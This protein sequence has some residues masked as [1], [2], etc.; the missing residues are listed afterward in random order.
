M[1][2]LRNLR[3]RNRWLRV[4]RWLGRIDSPMRGVSGDQ[5]IVESILNNFVSGT[6]E[7][8]YFTSHDGPTDP[9]SIRI[10]HSSRPLH[11]RK[12]SLE[13]AYRPGPCYGRLPVL[14]RE[15][16]ST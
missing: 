9:P 7:P 13:A 6:P 4:L 12:C 2:G 10:E 3:A 16:V 1:G 5:A 14:E 15:L 8:V 11:Y